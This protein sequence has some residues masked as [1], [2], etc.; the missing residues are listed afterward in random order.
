MNG[1]SCLWLYGSEARGDSDPLSDVDVLAVG[2]QNQ[3]I[4]QGLPPGAVV[5]RYSWTE[6]ELMAST[7]SLFLLH[8]K[9]EGKCLYESRD[10]KGRLARLLGD[11][12]EYKYVARD[13]T[14]FRLVAD[15]V[16][17]SARQEEGDLYFESSLIAATIR[18]ACILACYILRLP[19]FG[20]TEPVARAVALLQLDPQIANDFFDLYRVRLCTERSKDDGPGATWQQV[21]LWSSRLQKVLDEL[22]RIKNWEFSLPT[23]AR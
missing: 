14:G 5:S 18:H 19:C 17:E 3:R 21:R 1:G 23:H 8:V 6:V 13:L 9:T 16:E 2:T 7:G 15:D 10:V 20:R 12:P 11:L 4:E 22:D